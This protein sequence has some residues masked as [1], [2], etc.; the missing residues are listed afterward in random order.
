MR[1][2]NMLAQL[3]HAPE[4]DQ[5][6]GCST[7]GSSEAAMLAGLALKRRWQH[8]RRA[9]GSADR[10]AEPRDGDQ[11]PGLLGEVRELLGR[12]DA[13]GADGGRA[14]PPHRG[15]GGDALRRE[16]DRCRRD[17]R[18][19]LRRLIRAGAGD[20]RRPRRSPRTHGA[21]RA[22]PCRRSLRRVRRAVH[23]PRARLGLPASARRLDQR[24]GPQVRARVSGR[25]LDRL[26][27]RSCAPGRPDLPR[28]LSRRRHADVRA[29]L[30]APGR[31]GGRPVLQL[32]PPRAS[33]V[34]ARC[35]A[36]HATWRRDSPARSNELGVFRA[37]SRAARNY[38]CSPSPSRTRSTNFN[39]FDVS[40]ALRERG[41]LVPAYTF[42][43]NRTDLSAL[44]IVVRQ[45][46][47]HD[48]ADLLMHDLER[49]LPRLKAQTAPVQ[50]ADAAGFHH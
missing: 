15:G 31:T 27:R 39:V 13:A 29:Q 16:H 3:W 14:L 7:T 6:T 30:L 23:R 1:C 9:A 41:W 25:W 44:R 12:R 40:R 2:T 35:R 19:D 11:R 26:A 36:P 17:A 45:D 21:R 48:V 50:T 22:G 5:A 20:L 28:Q 33:T 8:A 38:R 10:P 47:S 46:F 43:A 24:L 49:Q 42:P 18:F 32:P 37:C 34:T 4:A